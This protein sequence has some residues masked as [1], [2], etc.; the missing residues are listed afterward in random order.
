MPDTILP[1]GVFDVNYVTEVIM[2]GGWVLDKAIDPSKIERAWKQLISAWPLLVSRLRKDPQTKQWQFHIPSEPSLSGSFSSLH[3]P[4]SLRSHYPYPATT[5]TLSCNAP[6]ES[7]TQIFYPFA[8]K[9]VNE[10]L[11][12]DRPVVYLHVTTFDDGSVIGLTTPHILSDAIGYMSIIKALCSVLATGQSP[13]ALDYTD[14]F[15]NFVPKQNENVP[16]PPNWRILTT[17]GGLML[18]LLSIWEA[19]FRVVWENRDVYFPRSEV[20]RIKEEAME[21]IRNRYGASTDRY[22]SSSDAI[23]AFMLKGI[24]VSARSNAPFNLLYTATMQSLFRKPRLPYLRN[25]TLLIVTP[26]L[27]LSAIP[28]LPLGEL[29]LHIRDTIQAQMKRESIEPW[30]RWQLANADKPKVFFNPWW[31]KYNL[32]TN[33]LAL[34]GMHLDFSRALPDDN[35]PPGEAAGG[36]SRQ[37]RCVWGARF[38]GMEPGGSR[39][40]MGLLRDDETGGI[41]GYAHL[42]KAVWQDKRGFGRYLRD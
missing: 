34:K 22:V 9:S 31:G 25:T 24:H 29:A 18:L 21:D 19:M 8:P 6:V 42:P 15:V 23:L 20:M 40:T 2:V 4:G 12:S 17:L 30:L 13:P 14:P 38:E 28:R 1:A 10:L 32:A 39:N 16:V 27:P 33:I 26:T 37:V 41:W 5:E 36:N 7:P 11:T 3:L 35:P